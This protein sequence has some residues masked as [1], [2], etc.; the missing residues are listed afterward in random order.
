[1]VIFDNPTYK[2]SH[3]LARKEIT[4]RMLGKKSAL[5][6]GI[7]TEPLRK[8]L[9]QMLQAIALKSDEKIKETISSTAIEFIP[10]GSVN[11]EACFPP[12]EPAF[13]L[14]DTGIADFAGNNS[15]IFSSLLHD[16]GKFSDQ[17]ILDYLFSSALIYFE[18]GE[19]WDSR[20]DAIFAPK[21]NY[22]EIPPSIVPKAMG[23]AHSLILFFALHELAHVIIDPNEL[24]DVDPWR[25]VSNILG[26]DAPPALSS[27]FGE[28][29]A[30]IMAFDLIMNFATFCVPDPKMAVNILSGLDI[31]L[32]FMMFFQGAFPN[33]QYSK[34]IIQ[35][36]EFMD[37]PAAFQRRIYFRERV[38]EK[39]KRFS[40][41]L[42]IDFL[43]EAQRCEELVFR[44]G[45]KIRNGA[46]P[47]KEF[48]LKRQLA[49]QVFE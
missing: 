6:K 20:R 12:S 16:E 32:T 41:H 24:K 43:S 25:E 48:Y 33:R 26:V 44:Y 23:H 30:D 17:E 36:N 39:M 34:K 4:G 3:K 27:Q 10:F 8:N 19:D 40:D 9:N 49:Y 31:G 5:V 46:T 14:L 29:I 35:V 15:A 47:S 13:V 21:L 28:S 42:A 37:H 38:K 2:H 45:E 22:S 1:M 7:A 18:R 11:G